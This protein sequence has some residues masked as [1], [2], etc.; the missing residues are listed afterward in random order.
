MPI[1]SN[2][3][4]ISSHA[5]YTI[6][7]SEPLIDFATPTLSKVVYVGGLGAKEPRRLEKVREVNSNNGFSTNFQEFDDILNMRS[8]TVLISFGSIVAAHK[9]KIDL[10]NSIV[11]VNFL[12]F[13]RFHISQYQTVK[14]FPEVTFIWKYE[15]PDDAF[16]TVFDFLSQ[17]TKT[18]L[19][20]ADP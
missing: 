4:E 1:R 10:K 18:L 6:I 12:H 3:Q 5:A 11:K 16:A 14:H 2:I 15:K 19:T 8:K 9:L 7:N 13:Y 17:I 20:T